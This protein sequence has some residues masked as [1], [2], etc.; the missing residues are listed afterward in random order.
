MSRSARPDRFANADLL[1]PLRY[2]HEHD[3]HDPDPSRDER[4][5]LMTNA[6][7]RTTPAMEANALFSESFE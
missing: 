1:R 4:D 3:V 5:R 6:P 2:A 7:I